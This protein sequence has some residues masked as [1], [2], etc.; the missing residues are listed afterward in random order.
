MYASTA[1]PA[2]NQNYFVF[3]NIL[4]PVSVTKLD[5]NGVVINKFCTFSCPN[6]IINVFDDGLGD[7]LV[8][9]YSLSTADGNIAA[10]AFCAVS[11]A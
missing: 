10:V 4:K 2:D 5:T 9:V 3:D 6:C 8:G 1:V 11:T 7:S